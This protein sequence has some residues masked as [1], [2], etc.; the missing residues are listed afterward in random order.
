MGH[1]NLALPQLSMPHLDNQQWLNVA[2]LAGG[3]LV[4][5]FAESWGSIRSLALQ[6][7]DSVAPN[8]ELFA[9]GAANLSSGLL[10]GMPVG[11]GFSASSANESAG[12]QSKFAGIFAALCVALLVI[13]GKSLIEHIP[14][15]VLAAAVMGALLHSLNPRPLMLLWRLDRDQYLSLAAL[16]GVLFFGVL[17][18]MLF[19]VALSIASA[20]RAFSAP[21]VKELVELGDSRNFVALL[22]HPEAVSNATKDPKI[23]I[24]R[25]EVP[26]FFANIDGV[27]DAIK[28]QIEA[29]R[30]TQI[31]ILSLEQSS[32]VD[33]SAAENLVELAA[34][35]KRRDI[36]LLLARVKDS[37][38]L[39]LQKVPNS[40]C[41]Q[42]EFWSVADAV[43]Y[44]KQQVSR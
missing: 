38:R 6:H 43:S 14:E 12:A 1:V 33:S 15:P 21:S 16:F 27:M 36:T 9:L 20:M 2:E 32:D 37:I 26:L 17:H 28:N 31:V 11:A 4:I 30:A 19:A 23:L 25:P 44:A 13:F 22:N 29:H 39:V 35:L 18:G 8:R 5:I 3:L 7:G 41:D 34:L 42:F 24:L 10:Q 40:T